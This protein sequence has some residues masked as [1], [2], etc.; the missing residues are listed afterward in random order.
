MLYRVSVEFRLTRGV[1]W[2]DDVDGFY[3]HV[4]AVRSK[5]EAHEGIAGVRAITDFAASVVIFDVLIDA[6]RHHIASAE[7]FRATRESIEEC[8]ARHFGMERP[9]KNTLDSA[10]AKPG[11]ETPIWHHRRM[12]VDVAA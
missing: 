6:E 8:G 3:G 1:A 7:S 11:L 5:I 4:E 12:L 2:A 9:G 10:G